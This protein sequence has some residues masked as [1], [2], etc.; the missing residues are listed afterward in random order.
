MQIKKK[1]VLTRKLILSKISEYDIYRFY[2]GEFSINKP[3]LN[4]LRGEKHPSLRVSG[5]F[6]KLSHF[7]FGDERYQGDCFDLVMQKFS[8]NFDTALSK[9]ASDFKIDKPIILNWTAPEIITKK[10]HVIQVR[11]KGYTQEELDYWKDYKITKE[12]LLE[13]ETYS[14]KEIIYDRKKWPIGDL[15]FAYKYGDNWKIYSPRAKREE[16]WVPNNTLITQIDGEVETC[17]KLIICKSRKDYRVVKKLHPYTI[18]LQ[19]ESLV[20]LSDENIQK[21][22]DR[23]KEVYLFF[24][25]DDPGV[26]ASTKITS[27]LNYKY[28][29]TPK[30]LLEKN[31]KDPSDWIKYA[32]Y[33]PLINFL[34][35]KN[36]L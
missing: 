2:L 3:F 18:G 15:K 13:D 9:I 35:N 25:S 19:N 7:D 10:P 29:N 30:E 28:I 8:C 36:I 5:S 23:V 12:D 22:R 17:D 24:D 11:I 4:P 20:A 14:P 32:D 27:F 26:K 34:K 16:K 33:D 6:N 1:T 31:I 21:I